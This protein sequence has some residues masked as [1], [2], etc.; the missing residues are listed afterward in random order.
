MRKIL[1][2]LLAVSLLVP[3]AC[4]SGPKEYTEYVYQE[5]QDDFI[6]D[7]PVLTDSQKENEF[8]LLG[9][10]MG[11]EPSEIEAALEERNSED[12]EESDEEEAADG[13]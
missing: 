10:A 1:M 2:L 13:E 5:R 6:W 4:A 3:V 7:N 8:W 9:A 11:M 12:G